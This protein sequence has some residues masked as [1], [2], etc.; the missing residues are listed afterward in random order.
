MKKKILFICGSLN[1]TTMM[2]KISQQ[3]TEF[4][5]YF[6]P[7]YADGLLGFFVGKGMF[8]FTVMGGKFR[9]A[10]EKFLN[11]KNLKIDYKG[12]QHEYDY[13]FTCS[14]LVIP[15]NIRKKKLV[16]VQEGMTDPEKLNY[17]IVKYLGLPRYLAATSM[18][19]L[20]HAYDL[21]CVASEGYKDLFIRKGCNPDKIVVTGIPNFDNCKEHLNNNFPHKNYVLVCTSDTRETISFENRK[22]T[23]LDAVKIANGRPMIFK[24]HPNEKVERATREINKYAPGALVFSSGNT[25]EMIANCDVLVTR[26]STVVYVG[27]ALGKEVYS[28]F[29]INM[30]RRLTPMQNGGNSHRNIA[31]IFRKRIVHQS[32]DICPEYMDSL[33][34]VKTV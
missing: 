1:Q 27:M 7:Y 14:D 22:K 19:G 6:T 12:Q 10:T 3:L 21:F 15:K 9:A 23:I 18:T 16:L 33:G 17:Y 13:V 11:E 20:S 25:N 8:E 5:Q 32:P 24:L 34:T 2:Y 30:L 4:D 31:D 26:Y 28:Y 29:D